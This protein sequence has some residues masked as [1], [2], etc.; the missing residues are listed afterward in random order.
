MAKNNLTKSNYIIFEIDP[1]NSVEDDQVRLK[2]NESQFQALQTLFEGDGKKEKT[3][4]INLKLNN[5]TFKF[6]RYYV[7]SEDDILYSENLEK[8][9]NLTKKEKAILIFLFRGYKQASIAFALKISINTYR[10]HRKN[11]YRKMGFISKFHLNSWSEKYLY[12]FLKNHP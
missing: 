1:I 11:L 8:Y 9:K 10:H 6:V 5:S 12:T 3:L 4:R 2:L 7:S